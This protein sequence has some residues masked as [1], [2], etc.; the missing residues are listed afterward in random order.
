[1]TDA[2]F[3]NEL[4]K[5]LNDLLDKMGKV[6]ANIEFQIEMSQHYQNEVDRIRAQLQNN[7]PPNFL[8]EYL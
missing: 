6:N 2:Q 1:M 7:F 3:F 4:K 8:A 5:M